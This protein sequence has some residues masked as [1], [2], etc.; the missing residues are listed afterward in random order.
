M[1]PPPR[2]QK[3]SIRPIVRILYYSVTYKIGYL[4]SLSYAKNKF[5]E[6]TAQSDKKLI[7]MEV[8]AG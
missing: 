6:F 2:G 1:E 8:G 4:P 3:A 5:A 7:E